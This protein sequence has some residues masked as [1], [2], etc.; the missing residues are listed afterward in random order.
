MFSGQ[1]QGVIAEAMIDNALAEGEW[2]V[3]K[4]FIFIDMKLISKVTNTLQEYFIL[5]FIFKPYISLHF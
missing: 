2:Y 4:Y 1:G 3:Q 5:Y